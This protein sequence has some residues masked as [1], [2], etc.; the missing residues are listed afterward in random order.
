MDHGAGHDSATLLYS[1]HPPVRSSN[2]PVRLSPFL[3]LL[4][5]LL[6]GQYIG[7]LTMS[8]TRHNASATSFERKRLRDR[9][10][11]QNLREKREN[12][13]RALEERVSYCEKNHGNELIHNCMLTVETVRRENE[14]LLARQEHLRRLFQGWVS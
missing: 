10:A 11:Q 12:R 6:T 3:F 9:R 4:L 1:G 14:L 8:S 7:Q 13:M 5:Y 2:L